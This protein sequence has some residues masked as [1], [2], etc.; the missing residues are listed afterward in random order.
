MPFRWPK[1][2]L[3][4][5]SVA[6]GRRHDITISTISNLPIVRES[7]N[8][9][10]VHLA[11]RRGL[12]EDGSSH[13]RSTDGD[14]EQRFQCSD[15]QNYSGRYVL[16]PLSLPSIIPVVIVFWTTTYLQ[17]YPFIL[18]QYTA[19]PSDVRVYRCIY[20]LSM[21]IISREF[22]PWNA[23]CSELLYSW[24][25]CSVDVGT[26]MNVSISVKWKIPAWAVKYANIEYAIFVIMVRYLVLWFCCCSLKVMLRNANAIEAS[27]K[28]VKGTGAGA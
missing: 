4:K 25:T 9:C 10:G 13:Y 22:F 2:V 16:L 17:C 18:K 27:L 8:V 28:L 11:T 7:S 21:I 12:H 26:P 20:V 24:L 14:N 6:W 3:T 1:T 15:E 19:H 5:S 23:M